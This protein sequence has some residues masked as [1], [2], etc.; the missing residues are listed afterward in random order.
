MLVDT[1]FYTLCLF[2]EGRWVE[3]VNGA[4][5]RYFKPGQYIVSFMLVFKRE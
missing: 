4:R 2:C 5:Q 1:S 3:I